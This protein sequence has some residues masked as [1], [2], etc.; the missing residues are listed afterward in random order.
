[1]AGLF[2]QMVVVYGIG[3]P[4]DPRDA[5]RAFRSWKANVLHL[6]T[7]SWRFTVNR[8]MNGKI[9]EYYDKIVIM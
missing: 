5:R 9:I 6:A 7:T 4:M 8:I 3:C 2:T 1:M